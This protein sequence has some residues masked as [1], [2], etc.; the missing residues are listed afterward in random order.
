ML[1]MRK[2]LTDSLTDVLVQGDIVR[3]FF[4][5]LTA[6]ALKWKKTWL[7]NVP[8]TLIIIVGDDI[9]S[10]NQIIIVIFIFVIFLTCFLAIL[11][12]KKKHK[13]NEVQ[14]KAQNLAYKIA[15]IFSFFYNI[16]LFILNVLNIQIASFKI[17]IMIGLLLTSIILIGICVFKNT[18]IFPNKH[19]NLHLVSTGGMSVIC[20]IYGIMKNDQ[21]D[22]IFLEQG[23]LNDDIIYLLIGLWGLS[24]L[25]IFFIKLI[26][27]RI[28]DNRKK[29]LTDMNDT[30]L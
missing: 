2:R 10:I 13:L 18:F 16:L 8:L 9:M 28:F 30:S 25:M 21:A 7:V 4:L 6:S 1:R 22:M 12:T 17:Q 24:L 14:I 26:I 19:G 15:F 23:K 29:K 11:I 5:I 20:S 3:P 27:D